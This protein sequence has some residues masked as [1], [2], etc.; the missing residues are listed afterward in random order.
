MGLRSRLRAWLAPPPDERV[1]LT[2]VLP[3]GAEQVVNA[4]RGETAWRASQ[5]LEVG[6]AG[7]CA[8]AA[9]G[10]CTVLLPSGAAVPACT[11]RVEGPLTLR[12]PHLWSMDQLR[13][14]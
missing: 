9:C 1:V 4:T 7:P 3:D 10:E 5:R 12:V 6:L 13:G 11:L 14:A 2:F 8:D